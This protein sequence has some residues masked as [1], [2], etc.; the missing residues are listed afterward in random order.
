MLEVKEIQK[1]RGGQIENEKEGWTG[2]EKQDGNVKKQD[3]YNR[4]FSENELE[5]IIENTKKK[6]Q[7]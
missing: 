3:W 7:H 2:C 1:I 5:G 4:P 6:G